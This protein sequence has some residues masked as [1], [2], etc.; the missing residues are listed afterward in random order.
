[1]T[2][3]QDTI[4]ETNHR[5]ADFFT[6]MWQPWMDNAQK[7]ASMMPVTDAKTMDARAAGMDELIDSC[8]DFAANL[9]SAQREVVKSGAAVA[10]AAV[11]NVMIST[12]SAVKTTATKKS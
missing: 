11:N 6:R 12:Q 1:M 5:A 3:A 10:R 4:T 9:L 8:Y 7:F 2:T